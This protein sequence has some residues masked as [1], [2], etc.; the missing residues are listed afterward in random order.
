MVENETQVKEQNQRH[1]QSQRAVETDFMKQE[2]KFRERL[3]MRKKAAIRIFDKYDESHEWGN[4]STIKMDS[5]LKSNN[6]PE[7]SVD[8][9][10][11]DVNLGTKAYCFYIYHAV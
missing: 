11:S 4:E 8:L 3:A 2:G 6:T 5:G 1:D 7:Q 10:T 9:N